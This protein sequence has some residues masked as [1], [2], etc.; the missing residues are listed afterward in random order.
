MAAGL[1]R[2]IGLTGVTTS[3]IA[4]SVLVATPPWPRSGGLPAGSGA[5]SL[6][7]RSARQGRSGG[8]ANGGEIPVIFF[9]ASGT[10]VGM[11]A[12]RQAALTDTAAIGAVVAAN[13]AAGR[14]PPGAVVFAT[15]ARLLVGSLAAVR[16]VW[17]FEKTR[18]V[19]AARMR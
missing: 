8:P 2:T 16:T 11:L 4:A 15:S 10:V 9:P 13:G 19:I 5:C 14:Q 1:C 17:L 7:R 3:V 12:P 18:T 6:E